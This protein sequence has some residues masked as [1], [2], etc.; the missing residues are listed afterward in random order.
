MNE[1]ITKLVEEKVLR[2]Y[3]LELLEKEK[4]NK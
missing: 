4:E 3:L 2:E 1:F